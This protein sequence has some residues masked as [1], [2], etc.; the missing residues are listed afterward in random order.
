MGGIIRV[1]Y[2]AAR[3]AR[4]NY[5]VRMASFASA[6]IPIGL[7]LAALGAPASAWVLF[8]LQ[9]FAYPHVL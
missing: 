5:C 6:A 4:T 7:Q 8:G 3:L 2:D 1:P 9:F